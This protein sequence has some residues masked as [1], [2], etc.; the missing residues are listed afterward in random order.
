MDTSPSEDDKSYLR[1]RSTAP[2]PPH[3]YDEDRFEGTVRSW[4]VCVGV[5]PEAPAGEPGAGN[6]AA[7]RSDATSP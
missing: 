1:C 7:P 2:H 5:P 6:D 3:H 4:S